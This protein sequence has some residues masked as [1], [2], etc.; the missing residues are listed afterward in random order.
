MSALLPASW[1]RDHGELER[2]LVL[3]PATNTV[4]HALVGDLPSLLGPGDVVVVNDSATLP[5]SLAGVL[6]AG[7]A[8]IEVRFFARDD[9]LTFRAILFGAGD[10]R[11]RTEDRPPPPPLAPGSRARFGDLD[12]TLSPLDI[13][14]RVVRVRFR[15]RADLV[16][17]LFAL[18]KPVQ[19]AHV[20]GELPL[21]SLQ[22]EFASRPWSF[23]MP[24]AS[25]PLTWA[26]LA[27][28]RARGVVLARLTHAAGLSSTG[29]AALDA[30]MPF[31]ERYEIPEETS[32]AVMRARDAGRHVLAV[33][34][35][36][37]RALESSG[38]AARSATT[39][40]RIRPESRLRVATALFTGMHEDGTSHA[41]LMRAFA[42]SDLLA[43]GYREAQDRGYLSHEF[44]D[45][46]LILGKATA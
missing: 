20:S 5:A 25:R 23:E 21:W 11:S 45:A 27:S 10:W 29:D 44:G 34:T 13:H 17:R 15:P 14:P 24:S 8:P 3:D 9:D 7:Q 12:A 35:T 30:L 43:R 39:T 19:Y 26:M 2:M 41:D 38:G 22:S 42:P 37:V 6:D 36:V 28:L 1:P 40:L 4:S 18:G 31:D 32:R 33:G 46:T 16:T